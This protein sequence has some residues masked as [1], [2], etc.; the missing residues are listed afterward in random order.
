MSQPIQPYEYQN[1]ESSAFLV[2]LLQTVLV[3]IRQGIFFG[4][5]TRIPYAITSV[6]RPILFNK[7]SRPLGKSI[8]FFS[9]QAIAHGWIIARIAVIFKLTER[10]LAM[11]SNK[12]GPLPW[13]TFIAGAFAG[14]MVMAR[15]KSYSTMKKQINMA[16]GIRTIYALAAYAVRKGMV[17]LPGVEHTEQGYQKGSAIFYTVMWGFVMWHWRHEAK[18]F[19]GEMNSAQV[20]QMD[21]IYN[22]FK[23]SEGW[24]Q[25]THLYWLSALLAIKNFL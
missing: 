1:L 18:P 12:R 3:A 6:L 20:N 15:D 22:D 25:S 14:Y 11:A 17:P 16:I 24:T 8:K 21:F 13:H 19:A 23:L 2:E 5:E 7:K 9:E 4:V 10:A